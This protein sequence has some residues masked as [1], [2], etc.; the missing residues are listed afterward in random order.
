MADPVIYLS[1]EIP[2]DTVVR[3]EGN[4]GPHL[5]GNAKTQEE[6]AGLS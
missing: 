1:D 6:N 3:S 5:I 4:D 2:A